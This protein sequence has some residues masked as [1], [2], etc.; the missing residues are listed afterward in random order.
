MFRSGLSLLRTNPN[1]NKDVLPLLQQTL[2]F[3]LDP[4]VSNCFPIVSRRSKETF[5]ERNPLRAPLL[6]CE[7]GE[8]EFLIDSAVARPLS[9]VA[10]GWYGWYKPPKTVYGKNPRNNMT[11]ESKK[12]EESSLFLLRPSPHS[13]PLLVLDNSGWHS[14]ALSSAQKKLQSK[15]A[16]RALNCRRCL[17]LAADASGLSGT[18]VGSRVFQRTG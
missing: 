3:P 15:N 18:G 12:S 10:C 9:R 13:V 14:S 5:G 8:R 1:V 2:L 11:N 4:T 16:T 17:R 7:R 6:V